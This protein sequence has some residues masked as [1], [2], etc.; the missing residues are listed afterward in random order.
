MI[1]FEK[2]SS[3]EELET[4]LAECEKNTKLGILIRIP[5][6]TNVSKA[7]LV[8]SEDHAIS[9]VSSI[10]ELYI[11]NN[12]G[13][14]QLSADVTTYQY[15][16]Y[17]RVRSNKLKREVFSCGNR[18]V[19][20]HIDAVILRQSRTSGI[21]DQYRFTSDGESFVFVL[22]GDKDVPS[23][24]RLLFPTE[25][26]FSLRYNS[27]YDTIV[28][29]PYTDGDTFELEFKTQTI[30]VKE[31]DFLFQ[32]VS[33]VKGVI[34]KANPSIYKFLTLTGSRYLEVEYRN[35]YKNSIVKLITTELDHAVLDR[36]D[37]MIESTKELY[38]M[39]EQESKNIIAKIKE[40]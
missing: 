18:V 37:V 21:I 24:D 22:E 26:L 16:K 38:K 8:S 4:L 27:M 35:I 7:I 31:S 1:K 14:L 10:T 20:G 2:V 9:N 5:S 13:N 25:A 40:L 29:F 17:D 3:V 30:T 32:P 36:L 28:V 12:Y 15:Y 6:S 11:F 23:R 34:A 33:V 19:A 39:Y